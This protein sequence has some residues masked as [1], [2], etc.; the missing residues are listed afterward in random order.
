MSA[1]AFYY[2]QFQMTAMFLTEI[3][4]FMSFVQIEIDLNAIQKG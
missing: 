3:N 4:C 2:N 1:F